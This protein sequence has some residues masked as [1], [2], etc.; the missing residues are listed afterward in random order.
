VWPGFF[1][2]WAIFKLGQME[3]GLPEMLQC[4]TALQAAHWVI[5]PRGIADI[6]LQA[7]RQQQGLQSI[8]EGFNLSRFTGAAIND[9][10][11]LRLKGEMLLLGNES[12]EAAQCFHNAIDV[13]CRQNAKS[14]EL[15]AVMSLARLLANEGCRDE[16]RTKL[17]DIYNWFIEGFDTMDLKEAKA[18][19]D[20]LQS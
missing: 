19:L 12:V 20:Q 10:E 6:C 15:R 7:G 5:A 11:L 1:H 13:A 2:G 3:E 16:A 14:W 9:A 18:L 17:I 8:A 4:Q